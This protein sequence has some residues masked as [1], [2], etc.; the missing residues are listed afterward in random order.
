MQPNR[1]CPW[2]EDVRQGEGAVSQ[3]PA[4]HMVEVAS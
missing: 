3:L 4:I 1:G 2:E